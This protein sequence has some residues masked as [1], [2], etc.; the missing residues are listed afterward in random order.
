MSDNGGKSNANTNNDFTNYHFEVSSSKFA[1][2]VDIFSQFF[3][4]PLFSKDSVDREM[5]AVDSEY[6]NG[7][8]DEGHATDYLEKSQ[9]AIPGSVIDDFSTGNLETLKVDGVYENLKKFYNNTYS[10]NR[11]NLVLVGKQS[12]DEL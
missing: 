2:G 4:E 8:S 11:M 6:N 12:L 7:K 10:S 5:H 1:E 3:K 9:V